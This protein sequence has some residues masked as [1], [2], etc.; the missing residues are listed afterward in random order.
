VGGPSSTLGS[1]LT[2]PVTD[3]RIDI[4]TQC[5][6]FPLPTVRSDCLPP[7]CPPTVTAAGGRHLSPRHCQIYQTDTPPCVI[8]VCNYRNRCTCARTSRSPARRPT[9][10]TGAPAGASRCLRRR[11]ARARVSGGRAGGRT[12]GDGARPVEPAQHTRGRKY[13][14]NR[15]ITFL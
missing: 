2:R 10:S 13:R 11:L 5:T 12:R 15:V 14:Y 4:Y 9:A 1:G 6:D 8:R 3:A 7:V